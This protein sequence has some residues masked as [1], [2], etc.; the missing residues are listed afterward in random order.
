MASRSDLR[1]NGQRQ[2]PRCGVAWPSPRE[3]E[4]LR[5]THAGPEEVVKQKPTFKERLCSRDTHKF[6]KYI[7]NTTTHG[8]V[9][10]FTGKSK[11]RRL[12]W[13]IVVVF[14]A[15]FCLYNIVDQMVVYAN[16]PTVTT[17]TQKANPGGIEFP[18][19]TICNLNPL[20]KS[21]FESI[22]GKDTLS[23]LNELLVYSSA[24]CSNETLLSYVKQNNHSYRHIQDAARHQAKDLVIS[25]TF[26]GE[27]CNYTDFNK[28]LTRLGYCYTFNSKRPILKS[29]GIGTRYGLSLTLNVEQY[30]YLD[31]PVRL[32]AGLKVVIHSQDEPPAPDDIGIALAPGR[33]MFLGIRQRNV[34]DTSTIGSRG[35]CHKVSD[36]TTFNFLRERFQYSSS[37]CRVDCFFTNITEECGCIDARVESPPLSSRYQGF[38]DC[39]LSDMYCCVN[40][41]YKQ[42]QV[43]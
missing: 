8:V 21:I 3:L 15:G 19:V 20:K 41:H 9:R 33:N 25:C 6:R 22:V 17:F 5:S 39:S 12:F 35:K 37:A 43:S 30:D 18:S 2:Q 14:A 36:T 4:N 10:I 29:K 34:A 28:I 13:A 7:E 32:D 27:E 16:N 23:A 40:E 24:A 11:V 42:A 31:W 1:H 26:A 38:S